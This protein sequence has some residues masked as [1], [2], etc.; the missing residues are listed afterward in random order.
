MWHIL[1]V[2]KVKL[3]ASEVYGGLKFKLTKMGD[4]VNILTRNLKKGNI[5]EVGRLL[6]N[7]L[8]IETIRLCPQL[9]KLKER[10]KSLNTKGVMV[11]GSG[12]SV[13]GITAGILVGV[14]IAFIFFN[15]VLG[16]NPSM[17]GLVYCVVLF[18][19]LGGWT[20]SVF[21]M[22]H[23]NYHL[24]KFHSSVRKGMTLLMIDARGDNEKEDAIKL[25]TAKHPEAELK[26]IDEH[27]SEIFL[28]PKTL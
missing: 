13:F 14:F 2:P 5:L 11:S 26:T 22:S 16:E 7:D 28:H 24:L 9:K 4:N 27:Y 8:E 17:P 19:I 25:M 6:V 20:G 23:L 21:G 10:L 3:Y 1:V 18:G 12:P 15:L